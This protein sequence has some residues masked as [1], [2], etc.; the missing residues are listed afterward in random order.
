MATEIVLSNGDPLS[1][2]LSLDLGDY[3]I[4]CRVLREDTATFEKEA[5]TS[6][7]SPQ[8]DMLQAK[9]NASKA[10]YQSER[11]ILVSLM[12]GY[13]GSQYWETIK[14]RLSQQCDKRCPIQ[15]KLKAWILPL[16]SF[17]GE[18]PLVIKGI[19]AGFTEILQNSIDAIVRQYL[20]N[21]AGDGVLNMRFELA[22]KDNAVILTILDNAG[23]FSDLQLEKFNESVC[24]KTY[25][26]LDGS[27]YKESAINFYFGKQHLGLSQLCRFIK[28][29]SVVELKDLGSSAVSSLQ[30]DNEPLNIPE[31]ETMPG[32]PAETRL[33]KGAKL[34]F[35]SPLVS[36]APKRVGSPFPPL[37]LGSLEGRKKKKSGETPLLTGESSR[38]ELN[39]SGRVR[40]FDDNPPQKVLMP[41]KSLDLP[42]C[43]EPR[44][45]HY[46]QVF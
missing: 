30:F 36:I 32:L 11:L 17:E 41:L 8:L 25:G 23:G 37:L 15:E 35:T 4:A 31:K 20:E 44:S 43:D 10:L 6:K 28:A 26:F 27:Q 12:K 38:L 18:L 9:M 2:N 13:L 19:D 40:F 3:C 14:K 42:C 34:I 5:S 33:T 1:V 22:S 16:D 46:P 29:S 39:E 7:C 21:A 45:Y 24:L